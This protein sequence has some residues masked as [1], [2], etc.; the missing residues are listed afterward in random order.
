M[1]SLPW[2]N[3][4]FGGSHHLLRARDALACA[5]LHETSFSHPWSSAEFEALLA[6]PSCV[7]D[8]LGDGKNLS[9]FILS[10]RAL[11]EAEVL[12]IAV[13]ASLRGKGYGH[14]LLS[15]HIGRLAS[16]G[17]RQLFLEV[18]EGNLPALALYAR[19]GFSIAGRREKYYAKADGGYGNALVMRRALN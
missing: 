13:S 7:G 5:R 17:V 18:D 11:D 15:L 10:R 9:G 1:I 4:P 3:A 6:D 16:L 12:T 14:R 2:R 19:F 8:G